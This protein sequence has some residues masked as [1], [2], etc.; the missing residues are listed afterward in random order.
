M[1]WIY[2]VLEVSLYQGIF[3]ALYHLALRRET[4]YQWSRFYLLLTTAIAFIIPLTEIGILKRISS[5]GLHLTRTASTRPALV[6]MP[7]NTVHYAPVWQYLVIA[8][9]ILIAVIL[10]CF[11]LFRLYRLFRLVKRNRK[12]Q[13]SAYQLVLFKGNQ[14]IFSFFNYLFA[15]DDL[16]LSTAVI[17][18]ELV[19]IRQKHSSDIVF[20]EM[21]KIICWFNPLV[22]LLQNSLKE[23]H[24]FIADRETSNAVNDTNWYTDFLVNSAYGAAQLALTNNFFNKS[25]LKNRIIMLHQKR[26]GRS[27]R[28]K[29]LLA[30][31]LLLASLCLSNLVFSKTY[32]W[33]RILPGQ[34]TDTTRVGTRVKILNEKGIKFVEDGYLVD[35]Q[36][37][38]KVEITDAKGNRH[39]YYSNSI[40]PADRAS[41]WEK[42][43]Y[44][45][46]TGDQKTGIPPPPPPM[47]PAVK[48]DIIKRPPPPPPARPLKNDSIKRPPPPPPARPLKKDMIKRPPPPPPAP[49]AAKLSRP[50]ENNITLSAGAKQ[51]SL[52][53]FLSPEEKAANKNPLLIINGEKYYLTNHLEK[54]QKLNFYAD[55][56]VAYTA[57][58]PH[59]RI[60]GQDAANGVVELKGKV[61]VTFN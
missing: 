26:S 28:L 41:V 15:S 20:I 42:Y 10:F 55:S 33:I 56:S 1:N 4:F 39:V 54:G 6:V 13:H 51:A 34:R 3:Y 32:R 5:A 38:Y 44:R 59:V 50:K 24:E 57:D 7:Q 25:Q 31:P 9:Y 2:Y 45:F 27:A 14:Q 49:P 11:F 48:R 22:Y 29:F 35:K 36:K 43:H 21:I 30:V 61:T 58:D 12:L 37:V 8:G 18:H 46:P 40:S 19:H 47:A 16:V 60:Y 23:L 17:T 52:K 53:T